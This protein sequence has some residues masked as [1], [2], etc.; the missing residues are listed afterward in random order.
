[1]YSEQVRAVIL[2]LSSPSP[3]V[4]SDK[5]DVAAVIAATDVGLCR[6]VPR[7]QG[8]PHILREAGGFS[9]EG[10]A[11]ELTEAGRMALEKL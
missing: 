11:V 10:V 1:M 7:H 3:H 4:F 2:I 9:D 6:L 5:R 8:A